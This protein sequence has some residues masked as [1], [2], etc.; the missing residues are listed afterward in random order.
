MNNENTVLY[1]REGKIAVITLNRPKKLNA[2]SVA[3]AKEL[4]GVWEKYNNDDDARVC[5]IRGEGRSFCTG[6]DLLDGL[7]TK[8]TM[9]SILAKSM[10]GIGME[11]WKPIISIIQGHCLGAGF[12]LA[13]QT[14][15]RI[16]SENTKFAYPEPRIG[17]AGGITC[18]LPKYMPIGLAMEF[19]LTGD[20]MSGKR[21]YEIGFA[22]KLC[23]E[24]ELYSEAW[25]IAERI[26]D[27]APLVVT[28]LKKLTSLST[29]P[30]IM[31]ITAL[32][33]RIISR[34]SESEDAIEGINAKI[35]NRKPNFIGR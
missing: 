2:L 9:A 29:Y 10:P 8:E 22:N 12:L 4:I 25:Q 31:E 5:I 26:A 6:M 27:N 20:L 15:I 30:S 7:K 34:V 11:V 23:P 1:K 16:V 18:S 3:M 33:N 13:M 28:G 14:D 35:E 19:L 32:G 17:L 21:A 24:E